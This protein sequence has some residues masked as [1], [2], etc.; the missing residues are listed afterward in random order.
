MCVGVC[1][2]ARLEQE[3]AEKIA[4]KQ[5]LLELNSKHKCH[6]TR[7]IQIMKKSVIKQ[8]F[9]HFKASYTKIP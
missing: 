2:C 7:E 6:W 3:T 8:T 4:V 9:S 1:V 5:C